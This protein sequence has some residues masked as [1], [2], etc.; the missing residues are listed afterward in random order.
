LRDDLPKARVR[1]GPRWLPPRG[2]SR[3]QD[4]VAVTPNQP[5]CRSNDGHRLKPSAASD[6]AGSVSK[7][8]AEKSPRLKAFSSAQV[9]KAAASRAK[10]TQRHALRGAFDKGT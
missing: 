7:V 4:V 1:L 2:A 6:N 5:R 9:S 8:V 3:W 10:Q